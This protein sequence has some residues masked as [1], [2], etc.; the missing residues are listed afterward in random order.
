MAIDV[1]DL[2]RDMDDEELAE[3]FA[4]AQA[5]AAEYRRNANQFEQEIMDRL[6][7]RECTQIAAGEW[8]IEQKP[9]PKSYSYDV[10]VLTALKSMLA[11]GEWEALVTEIQRPVEYK[12]QTLKLKSLAA[13]RGPVFAAIVERATTVT[14][15]PGKVV[16]ER[17]PNYDAEL[18]ASVAQ[19]TAARRGA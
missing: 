12:V 5:L 13:K 10:R 14:V 15:G 19:A 4:K 7:A 6:A 11:P 9:G 2:A 18:S 3:A 16:A 1:R 17:L 8:L